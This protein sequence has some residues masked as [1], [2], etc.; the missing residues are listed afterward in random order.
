MR[1]IK[2]FALIV[3][4]VLMTCLCVVS[5]SACLGRGDRFGAGKESSA[6]TSAVCE[7]EWH[8]INYT[9]ATC[10]VAGKIEQVCKTCGAKSTEPVPALG[11]K[12]YD[13]AGKAATCTEAGWTAG[14]KCGVCGVDVVPTTPIAAKGHRTIKEASCQNKAEC[15]VC[16]EYGEKLQHEPKLVVTGAKLPTCTEAGWD[17]YTWC[18]ATW[19][20]IVD[21][22]TVIKSCPYSTKVELAANGHDKNFDDTSADFV[23]SL[24][25]TCTELAYCGVCEMNYG[26]F[27][28][29][30]KN[31]ETH[32]VCTSERDVCK[33]CGEHFG[34]FPA[35][36]VHVLGY[37]EN[38]DRTTDFIALEEDDVMCALPAGTEI[39]CEV[40]DFVVE[41]T[42]GHRYD[43]VSK[44]QPTCYSE[45]HYGY[46]VCADCGEMRTIADTT[47]GIAADLLIEDDKIYLD[48]TDSTQTVPFNLAAL[49]HSIGLSVTAGIAPTCEAMGQTREVVCLTCCVAYEKAQ[50]LTALGHDGFRMYHW[51]DGTNDTL[52][53]A[54]WLNG[55]EADKVGGYLEKAVKGE[56]VHDKSHPLLCGEAIK[57]CADCKEAL[58][59]E[60]D[61]KYV[62]AYCGICDKHHGEIGRNIHYGGSSVCTEA[63]ICAGCGIEYRAAGA[64]TEKI[65]P[66]QPATC[67]EYG[68]SDGI[69]C[70]VCSV[71]IREKQRSEKVDHDQLG[72]I[73][74][75]APTEDECGYTE[76]RYCSMCK[77]VVTVEPEEIPALGKTHEHE[78]DENNECILPDC[79]DKKDEEEAP[80]E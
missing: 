72:I 4:T 52:S 41:E 10:T 66:G 36:N 56:F 40:C 27:A 44:K 31:D 46:K 37:Y 54:D 80:I 38:N 67:T 24:K 35:S 15:S 74:A 77:A 21:G 19:V 25:A 22:E 7:H 28:A 69:I 16:G 57:D 33:V 39:I 61:D 71:L 59:N 49:D 30:E 8:R 58:K 34:D 2:R 79:P 73:E 29:H 6:A 65:L 13:V 14:Q 64:H 18:K 12:P 32:A 17:D 9:E 62:R 3:M 11:H 48:I 23:G 1:K 53:Y 70:T 68:F 47:A 55:G 76:G 26:D 63:A 45:G 42:L 5:L 43:E 60:Y 20:E 78:Y 50:T 51:V 75:I